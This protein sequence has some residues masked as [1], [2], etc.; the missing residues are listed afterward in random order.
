M[1]KKR[2]KGGGKEIKTTSA[3]DIKKEAVY[4]KPLL[5]YI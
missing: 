4:R 3:Q 5:F 2:N 1:M